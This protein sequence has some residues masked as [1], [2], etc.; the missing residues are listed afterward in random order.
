MNPITITTAFSWVPVTVDLS[1]FTGLQIAVN[2]SVKAGR[3]SAVNNWNYLGIDDLCIVGIYVSFIIS[4]K[5]LTQETP[6]C[7]RYFY[8]PGEVEGVDYRSPS[9]SWSAAGITQL[10][11]L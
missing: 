2:I 8:S 3:T 9:F 4:S 10:H 5:G 7:S 11:N 1:Y 6:S